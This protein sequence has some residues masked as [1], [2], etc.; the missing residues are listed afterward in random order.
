MRLRGITLANFK[1]FAGE[2]EIPLDKITCLIGR[3]GAGKSNVLY[4]LERIATVLLGGNYRPEKADYFNDNDG[5]EMRL[6]VTFEL[7][8]AE[9]KALLDRPKT[10]SVAYLHRDLVGSPLFRRAKYTVSFRNSPEQSRE[11]I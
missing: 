4:G 11:E 7:F 5:A 9:Q 8:D 3:N 6:G 10:K 1:S 2:V